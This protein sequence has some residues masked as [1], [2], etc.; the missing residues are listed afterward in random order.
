[1]HVP[2]VDADGN[3]YA[4]FWERRRGFGPA[5]PA[6]G[7][8]IAIDGS[9][10]DWKNV[11]V[12]ATDPVGD[13]PGGADLR[14]VKVVATKTTLFALVELANEPP[15]DLTLQ[16]DIGVNGA[17]DRRVLVFCGNGVADVLKAGEGGKWA[18]S[19][20]GHRILYA[21][22]GA[23]A[24]EVAVPLDLIGHAPALDLRAT[25]LSNG[26]VDGGHDP[27]TI[28]VPIPE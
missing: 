21:L 26:V 4:D 11:P 8:R 14:A 13:A 1:M 25:V 5:D 3:G 19:N 17:F 27:A 7:P 22:A 2:P 23:R 15:R 6:D 20:A 10:A 12:S 28:H 16:L 24:L 18:W 9:D